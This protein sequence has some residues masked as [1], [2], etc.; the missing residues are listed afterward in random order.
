MWFTSGHDMEGQWRKWLAEQGGTAKA[1]SS[2]R[3]RH[4]LPRRRP[5]RPASRVFHG[6]E[7]HFGVVVQQVMK[8][9]QP[10][11]LDVLDISAQPRRPRRSSQ[12][13]CHT[14]R[15]GATWPHAVRCRWVRHGLLWFGASCIWSAAGTSPPPC[16][17][18][19]SSCACHQ[20]RV[21]HEKSDG[22]I[23]RKQSR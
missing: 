9:A 20:T 7:L 23:K 15:S 14:Q 19:Q 13:I 5:T 11:T 22:G 21:V 16:S 12:R 3:K 1:P 4:H 2:Y 17:T 10:L 8:S 6:R 18:M